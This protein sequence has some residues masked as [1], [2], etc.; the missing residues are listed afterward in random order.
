MQNRIYYIAVLVVL[1]FYSLKTE[2]Q[3]NDARLWLTA[4]LQKNITQ[5]M[6]AEG[7]ASIRF[8][9][10]IS[11]IG[12]YYGDIGIGY[13]LIKRLRIEAHYRYSGK[14]KRDGTFHLRHRYYADLYY[15]IKTKTPFSITLKVR[16]QKQ[17]T[18]VFTSETGFNPANTLREETTVSYKYK[19]YEPF[20]GAEIFYL[21]DNSGKYFNRIR[22][23][24]GTDY[25]IN[26]RNSLTFFYMI[27]QELNSENP[28]RAFIMGVGY[29]YTL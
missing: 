24:V 6:Y 17:Y 23:K 12:A 28:T 27:Q 19:K 18:D 1:F 15:K 4:G 2:A 25:D 22:Y 8:N 21:M 29:K 20:I 13:K 5:K 16:F 10:N 26:K 7:K 11:E 9:E 14:S 3:V